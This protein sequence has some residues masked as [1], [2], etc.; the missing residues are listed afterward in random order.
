[1]S[2][3]KLR[4]LLDRWVQAIEAK[5]LDALA[6]VF[7]ASDELSVFWSNGE[8]TLGWEEVRRHIKVDFR[9]EVDLTMTIHDVHTT[10]MGEDA[11]VLT[12]GYDITVTAG[13]DAVTCSRRASMTVHRDA[14]G[15]RIAS[16]HVSTAPPPPSHG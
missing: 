1:M 4:E 8:R 15:W 7:R 5:D 3:S 16:L 10:A 9:K 6:R 2:Q 11:S 13:E 12:F 14:Q